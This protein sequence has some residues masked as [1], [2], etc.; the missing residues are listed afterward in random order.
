MVPTL[1][2]IA[3]D[4]D[5]EAIAL[6]EEVEAE[7]HQTST[8][9][10]PEEPAAASDPQSDAEAHRVKAADD[11]ARGERRVAQVDVE[12]EEDVAHV[13]MNRDMNWWVDDLARRRKSWTLRWRTIGARREE[14]MHR[15]GMAR[16][17]LRATERM[18]VPGISIWIFEGF[19]MPN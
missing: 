3:A 15:L 9:T 18:A 17:L 11:Q 13:P 19:E 12:A 14:M 8:A 7:R 10:Y 6:A 5:S 16:R 4:E 1:E 2:T